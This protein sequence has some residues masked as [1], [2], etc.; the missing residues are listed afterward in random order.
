GA[1]GADLGAAIQDLDGHGLLLSSDGG[2]TW[3]QSVVLSFDAAD[4]SWSAAQTVMVKVDDGTD[5][6][7]GRAIDLSGLN[8]RV[9]V[10][11]FSTL[12]GLRDVA[13]PPIVVPVAENGYTGPANTPDK[14]RAPRPT[15][16]P[17]ISVD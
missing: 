6:G 7:P 16:Q 8:L 5:A 4:G 11:L 2:A 15:D 10:S 9:A 3:H 12:P 13:L 1:G 14:V 17:L